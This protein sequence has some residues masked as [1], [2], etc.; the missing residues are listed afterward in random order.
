[1]IQHGE[2]NI[3]VDQEKIDLRG[4]LLMSTVLFAVK[5]LNYITVMASFIPK[6]IFKKPV[7]K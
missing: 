4:T 1:M 7:G 2:N 5:T 3:L 6:F